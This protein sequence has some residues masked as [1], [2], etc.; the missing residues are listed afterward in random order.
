MRVD[1]WSP[2]EG[3]LY[4]EYDRLLISDAD[5]ILY[6]LRNSSTPRVVSIPTSEVQQIGPFVLENQDNCGMI[7]TNKWLKQNFTS[8]SCF[9]PL[10]LVKDT[11]IL[12]PLEN[13]K[14]A[15]IT[16]V[17]LRIRPHPETGK[18]LLM[19]LHILLS[20]NLYVFVYVYLLQLQNMILSLLP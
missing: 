17:I 8:I 7:F 4:A 6:K 13:N 15:A 9:V 12:W 3:Y 2:D 14:F 11:T 18:L 1:L 10:F 16:K 19:N 5:V 20:L